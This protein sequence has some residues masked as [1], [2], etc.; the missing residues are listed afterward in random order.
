MRYDTLIVGAGLSGLSAGIRLARAGERV[1]VLERHYLWGGLNSF[2]KL[3]GRRFDSGLHALTNWAPPGEKKSQLARLLRALRIDRDELKLGQQSSSFVAFLLDGAQVRLRFS[4]D[5]ALLRSEIARLFPG[6][7]DRFETLLTEL[8]DYGAPRQAEPGARSMLAQTLREPLLCEMLLCAPCLYGSAREDDMDWDA[9]AVLFRSIFLEGLCRP[10]GGIKPLLDILRRRLREEGGELRTRCGVKRILLC[11]ER[12]LGVE[13][14]DGSELECAHILSSAGLVETLELCGRLPAE[15][16]APQAG[17]ISVLETI[18]VLD[19]PTR[20]LGHAE[21]IGFFNQGER[22]RWSRPR[23]ACEVRTGVIACP[24]NYQGQE[25]LP[26]G[27]FRVSVLADP[28]SWEAL[29]EPEYAPSKARWSEAAIESAAR[30]AFDPRAHEVQRDVFTPR[31]IRRFTGHAGGAL[32]GSPDKRRGGSIGLENV[33]LIGNDESYPGI[34][35]ALMSGI[36]VASRV[37]LAQRR[38]SVESLG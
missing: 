34:V 2:Y 31:T 1:A 20:E 15:S 30:F 10:S 9:F 8:P 23:E 27:R 21:T 14:D 11:G 24:D 12:A 28:A 26:E 33:L 25:D 19:R 38:P 13:L 6:E 7:R 29:S 3:A 4:N 18:S 36:G 5:L 35:G 17:R 37:A 32:Y 16:D 22:L